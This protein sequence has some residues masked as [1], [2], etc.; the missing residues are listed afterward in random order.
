MKE[1]IIYPAAITIFGAKGDLTHRKL[2][3]ALYNLFIDDHLPL[4]F[5]IFC[6]DYLK[7]IE[8]EFKKDLHEGINEFSRSGKAD[9]KKWNEFSSMIYYLQG[10]FLKMETYIGLK[11]RLNSFDKQNKQRSTRLY[12]FAVAPR[13]IEI[14]S[15]SL[16]EQKICHQAKRDRII[17]EKPFGTDLQSSRKLNLFLRERFAE[18]Q[19]YRIDHYLG[20]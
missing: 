11:G 19:I 18:S 9:E 15:D 4:T 20:K 13:F 14:I 8:S 17:I 6:I 3:P 12:Y 10:D 2:I 1:K 7:V 16:N 5:V